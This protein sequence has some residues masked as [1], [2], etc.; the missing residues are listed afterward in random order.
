MDP[1]ST[2]RRARRSTARRPSS[3]SGPDLRSA[4]IGPWLHF[5]NALQPNY[6][7]LTALGETAPRPPSPGPTG[8]FPARRSPGTGAEP[9]STIARAEALPHPHDA[10]GNAGSHGRRP[11]GLGED[12]LLEGRDQ[13]LVRRRAR[14]RHLPDPLLRAGDPEPA[15]RRALLRR[16]GQRDP[17]RDARPAAPQ[18]PAG[19]RGLGEA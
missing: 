13:R 11:A 17:A 18:G 5:T 1:A 19:E 8:V 14:R 10:G 2:R 12:T 15:G 16:R 9:F 3:L 7:R 4:P 6:P